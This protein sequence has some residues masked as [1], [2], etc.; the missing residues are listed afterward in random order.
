MN[1]FGFSI[2]RPKTKTALHKDNKKLTEFAFEIEGTKFY[3]FKNY[4]DMPVLRYSKLNEFIRE[5]ELRMTRDDLKEYLESIVSALEQGKIIDVSKFITLIDFRLDSFLE[6]GTYYRL[7]SC[8]FFTEDEDLTI[9]DVDYNDWKIEQFKKEPAH[10]FFLRSPM[11]ELL[12]PADLSEEDIKT[13]LKA[14]NVS[15]QYEQKI[16]SSVSTKTQTA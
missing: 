14:Q 3:H 6:L 12:P 7:F 16:R 5:A 8:A 9:Y 11:K 2:T 13:F 15:K 4:L 10:S 1:I